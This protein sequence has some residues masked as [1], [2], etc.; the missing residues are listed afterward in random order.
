MAKLHLSSVGL[1]G[2]PRGLFLAAEIAL[3]AAA[4]GGLA[5]AIPGMSFCM[6][7]KIISRDFSSDNLVMRNSQQEAPPTHAH[8]IIFVVI[9]CKTLMQ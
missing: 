9:F 7:V 2:E 3:R 6:S 4:R 1:A 8:L 5:Q